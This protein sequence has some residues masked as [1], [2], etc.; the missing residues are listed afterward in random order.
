[1]IENSKDV[2]FEKEDSINY[3]S[4]LLSI[5]KFDIEKLPLIQQNKRIESIKL[6]ITKGADLG[7]SSF[8]KVIDLKILLKR[9]Y[10]ILFYV[11]QKI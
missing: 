7:K 10:L 1:M 5:L 3:L 8:Q 6:L 2:S 11:F 4:E 9:L